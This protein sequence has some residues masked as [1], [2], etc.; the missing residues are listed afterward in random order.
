MSSLA[1][2]REFL[3]K[4]GISAAAANLVLHLPSL[5]TAAGSALSRKQRLIVVFSPNGVIPDHFWPDQAGADFDVKRIL[6][7]LAP[8]K[9]QLV[10][11]KGLGNRI[12]GDGDGH[13]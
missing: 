12:K 13:M 9:S 4:A 10:T 3:V 2:R 6:E 11:M 5:A 8:F 1:T 7:P